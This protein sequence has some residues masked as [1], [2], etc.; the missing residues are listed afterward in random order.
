[1]SHEVQLERNIGLFE[2]AATRAQRSFDD[3]DFGGTLSWVRI[4]GSL[5]FQR[6]PGF[7][8]HP[9]FENML[10]VIGNAIKPESGWNVMKPSSC[11]RKKFHLLHVLTTALVVGGH[12]RLV[13]R[14]ILN[15]RLFS[16]DAHS[17]LVL[18]QHR[19]PFPLW[20]KQ[21]SE[22][23]GGSCTV[24]PH[25]MDM[26]E[27]ALALR[28]HAYET[29]DVVVLH[30]H[31]NDPVAV[32][33]FAPAGGPPV[34][35][36]NHADDRFWLGTGVTDMIV[37]FREVGR[38]ISHQRRKAK[39][40]E[41]L[42]I[43]LIPRYEVPP[44]GACKRKLNIPEEAIILLSI[45]TSYKFGPYGSLDFPKA[46]IEITHR[47]RNVVC[48]AIGPSGTEA[49]W[50]SAFQKTHGKVR[51]LGVLQNIQ[52]YYG[53]A[54]IYVESFPFGSLTATLDAA[55]FGK[56]VIR[57][58]LRPVPMLGIDR[59]E[60]MCDNAADME[61]YLETLSSYINDPGLRHDAG[62][63]QRRAVEGMH[64][65]SGWSKFCKHVMNNVPPQHDVLQYASGERDTGTQEDFIWADIQVAESKYE[66]EDLSLFNKAFLKSPKLFS[67][68]EMT[69]ALLSYLRR[70]VPL[71]NRRN[72]LELGKTLTFIVLP[73]RIIDK[74]FSLYYKRIYKS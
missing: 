53:A 17:I 73:S 42:P 60:G 49:V 30:V 39:R 55:L 3:G 12:T 2:W 16:N 8:F 34:L 25:G 14:W 33:A 19:A 35:L 71:F 21:A 13:E 6:H 64:V 26:I 15:S 52:D 18:D 56:P 47:H 74:I 45:G 61:T 72:F 27:Q 22:N 43:P 44:S 1:M 67:K 66:G 24:L 59:Y 5:A 9:D 65:G 10:Q 41:L 36:L 37:D 68:T 70:F 46:M 23:S 28:R 32:I 40:S 57:M 4:A 11:P 31:P 58:P 20:L 7:Y 50:K 38:T 62:M 69:Q 54:D 63:M 29:A 48:L 51:A